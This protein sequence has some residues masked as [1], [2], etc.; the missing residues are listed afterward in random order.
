MNGRAALPG[1]PFWAGCAV[2]VARGCHA[3]H[4]NVRRE[5]TEFRAAATVTTGSVVWPQGLT[6]SGKTAEPRIG[7][8]SGGLP[9]QFR[10]RVP[11][12]QAW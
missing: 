11:V 7:A 4:R 8:E 10:S 2:L 1:R 9:R 12:A 3:V 6:G 5:S